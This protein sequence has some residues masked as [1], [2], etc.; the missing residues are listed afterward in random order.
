MK[1]EALVLRTEVRLLLVLAAWLCC[2]FAQSVSAGPVCTPSCSGYFSC[3][4][5]F[6]HGVAASTEWQVLLG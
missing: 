5:D 4:R 1:Q 3:S 6:L 2:V